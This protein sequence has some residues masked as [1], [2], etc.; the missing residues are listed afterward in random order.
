MKELSMEIER[1]T[2]IL[3]DIYLINKTIH[4]IINLKLR[5]N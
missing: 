4:K 1:K 3:S 2:P 5:M